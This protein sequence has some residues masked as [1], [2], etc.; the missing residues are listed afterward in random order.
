MTLSNQPFLNITNSRWRHIQRLFSI[1]AIA[2]IISAI[3]IR[4]DHINAIRYLYDNAFPNYQALEIISKHQLPLLGQPSSITF[5]HPPLTS[6]LIAIILQ[7]GGTPL[8]AAGVIAF[9]NGFSPLFV[10]LTARNITR[11]T[12]LSLLAALLVAFNPWLIEYSRMSWPPALMPVLVPFLTW[13]LYPVLAGQAQNPTRRTVMAL[14]ALALTISSFLWA[15]F[16]LIPVGVLLII[17]RK[18]A[19]YRGLLIGGLI[20]AAYVALFA[21]AALSVDRITESSSEVLTRNPA[22]FKLEALSH[23]A[24][25]VTGAAYAEARADNAIDAEI[26]QRLGLI[27]EIALTLPLIVGMLTALA[28]VIRGK[29]GSVRRDYAAIVLVFFLLPIAAM[30]YIGSP[31]HPYY[32]LLTVPAGTLIALWG[33]EWLWRGRVMPVMITASALLICGLWAYEIQRFAHLT[34]ETPGKD[35]LNNLPLSDAVRLGESIA[36]QP[37]NDRIFAD[38]YEWIASSATGELL[39]VQPDNRERLIVAPAEGGLYIALS[40]STASPLP[41]G[42]SAAVLTLADNSRITLE[43]IRAAQ[44]EAAIAHRLDVPTENGL[45]LLG[46]TYDTAGSAS[47][48]QTFWLVTAVD[49]ATNPDAFGAFVHLDRPDGSRIDN[50]DG[51][52]IPGYDWRTGDIHAHTTR[53]DTPE[54]NYRILIGQYDPFQSKPLI[55]IRPDGVYTDRIEIP[56]N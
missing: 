55:F 56:H 30:S 54:E 22:V 1:L 24:R 37:E 48:L 49:F 13:L 10:Y 38:I 19:T 52:I 44:A 46:Y 28:A 11:K 45:T 42:E 41:F 40:S 12:G 15:F 43:S 7:L 53:F 39:T 4:L 29:W 26:R 6:Y 34:L 16:L 33:I 36:A 35:G 17:F 8:T 50:I 51:A 23:A 14:A 5:P 2:I 9:L 47:S 31:V 18:R 25:M 20:V 3:F 21:T 32:M 27:A